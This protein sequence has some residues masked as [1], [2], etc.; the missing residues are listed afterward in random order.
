MEVSTYQSIETELKGNIAYIRFNR[1]KSLNAL[2]TE[3]IKELVACLNEIKMNTG[4][5]IVVLQGNETGF[6]SGGDIK[7][8]LQL[9][10]Q[11]QFFVI[12]D[13]INELITTLYTMPKLTIAAINGAAAGLGLSIALA[14]DHIISDI[15]SKFAMNF[16]GIGLVPDGGGHFLLELRIGENKAKKL[17]WDGKVLTAKEAYELELIDEVADQVQVALVNKIN[18]WKSKPLAAMIETKQIYVELKRQSLLK[19]FELEKNAQWKMRQTIDHKEGI[20]AFVE[21]RKPNFIG[22]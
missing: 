6:S 19:A 11:E 20:K 13:Q 15:N 22:R 3:M 9:A 14:T 21:K 7:E 17:I 18:L 1:P 16:I 8:M 5:Q 12:M 4:I 2:N 10:G